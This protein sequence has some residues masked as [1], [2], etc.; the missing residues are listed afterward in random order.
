MI[1][2]IQNELVKIF[3]KKMSWIFAI[4]LVIALI[5]GAILEIKTAPQYKGDDWRAHVQEEIDRLTEELKTAPTEE[6]LMA[7]EDYASLDQSKESIQYKIDDFQNNLDKDV[8]PY[9]TSWSFMSNIG[10]G[11][12]SLVTLFVVI[13]CA[14]NISSEFSD[15]TIKQLLIR[16]HRR[17]AILL[18]KYIA[19]IFYSVFLMAVLV[20]IGYIVSIAFFG[21]QSFG[22]KIFATNVISYEMVAVKGGVHFFT[23]LLYYLPGLLLVLTLAFMLS[24]LFKNQAIA[25]GVG[26]FILF[27]SS[28]LGG[29]IILLAEK[30]AWAKILIFPHLDQTVFV[31]QDKILETITM[32]MSLGILAVYYLIF[33]AVTFI[34]FQ[35]RDISI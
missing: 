24:T 6:S 9:S 11:M 16:P 27:V 5:G 1:G 7:S 10:I 32:P 14:G 20:G 33:M 18:S 13:V 12:K 2:L 4:I 25:V 23:S 15:G 30:Y 28:T 17:W 31:L 22:D 34:F 26:V 19:L 29:L 21:G 3:E 8:S 35:K